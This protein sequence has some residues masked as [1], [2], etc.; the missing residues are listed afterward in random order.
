MLRV[1]SQ[2]VR[3]DV[4][5]REVTGRGEAAFELVE[6]TEVEIDV[7]ADRAI[8]G[9]H[10]RLRGSAARHRAVSE[11][12]E[13]RRP[14]LSARPLERAGPRILHVVE[15]LRDELHLRLLARGIR[16]HVAVRRFGRGA[17]ARKYSRIEDQAENQH[18][19]ATADA[20]RRQAASAPVLEVRTSPARA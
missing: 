12:H 18:H 10:R 19:Q 20:D 6:E 7:S 3:D 4:R 1:V 5:A 11:E 8:E 14:I 15:Y 13:L 9:T 2:L 17:V 16:R